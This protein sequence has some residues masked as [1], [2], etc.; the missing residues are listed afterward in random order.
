MLSINKKGRN[1]NTKYTLA[2][3]VHGFGLVFDQSTLEVQ[4]SNLARSNF[5][6]L[7]IFLFFFLLTHLNSNLKQLLKRYNFYKHQISCFGAYGIQ[8][9]SFCLTVWRL[10]SQKLVKSYKLERKAKGK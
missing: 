7:F 9:S 6:K 3:M 5:Q 8:Q 4:G 10:S 1:Y 2:Q